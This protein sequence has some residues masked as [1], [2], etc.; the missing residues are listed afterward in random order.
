[1]VAPSESYIKPI[2]RVL[3]RLDGVE[4]HNGYFKALCPVHGD[5]NPSLSV[6]E[7]EDGRV[8]LNCFVGCE[9]RQFV[10]TLGLSM[11]DIF[12]SPNGHTG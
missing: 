3:D 7:G 12:D 10:D 4:K 1:M 2:E 11:R 5:T 8:L 6:S 9:T